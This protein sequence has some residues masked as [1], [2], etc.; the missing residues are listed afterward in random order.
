M[1]TYFFVT[2]GIEFGIAFGITRV[3]K[4]IRN[5]EDELF[6]RMSASEEISN[7]KLYTKLKKHVDTRKKRMKKLEKWFA[8]DYEEQD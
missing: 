1:T 7:I 6:E 8:F 4:Y 3:I 2:L 5:L